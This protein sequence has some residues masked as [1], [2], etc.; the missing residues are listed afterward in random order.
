MSFKEKIFEKLPEKISVKGFNFFTIGI[1]VLMV[2]ADIVLFILNLTGNIDII[3]ENFFITLI[4]FLVVFFFYLIFYFIALYN[5][6]VC[7][8]CGRKYYLRI[9]EYSSCDKCGN[10]LKIE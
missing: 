2:S 4:L 6:I 1:F 7:N 3:S 9:R 10:F 8:N 5:R